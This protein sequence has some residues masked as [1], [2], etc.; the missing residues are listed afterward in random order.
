MICQPFGVLAKF[1]SAFWRTVRSVMPSVE[2]V[3]S[4]T[5]QDSNSIHSLNSCVVRSA[6]PQRRPKNFRTVSTA[7]FGLRWKS[8]IPEMEMPSI[9][10]EW[11]ARGLFR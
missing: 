4:E 2:I 11:L 3:T 7:F 8:M 5:K 10:P 9:R 6:R 1:R